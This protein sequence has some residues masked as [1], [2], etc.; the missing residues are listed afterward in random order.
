MILLRICDSNVPVDTHAADVMR[1][2][3]VTHGGVTALNQ[4][5]MVDH[6][7]GNKRHQV[8]VGRPHVPVAQWL[9]LPVAYILILI[10]QC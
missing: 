9:W 10:F 4:P 2:M 1:L 8:V 7:V 5:W 6:P 3:S